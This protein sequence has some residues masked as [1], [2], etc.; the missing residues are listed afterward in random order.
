MTGASARLPRRN[1]SFV[2]RAIEITFTEP[3]GQTLQ[4]FADE[5]D[6]QQGK[7]QAVLVEKMLSDADLM[8]QM[9]VADGP[10]M[11]KKVKPF[12]ISRIFAT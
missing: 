12:L 2:A 5:K 7:E 10:Q 11:S 6:G 3:R 4:Q 1:R 9:L 8:K